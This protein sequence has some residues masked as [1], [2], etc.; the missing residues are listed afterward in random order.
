ML[1]CGW[2]NFFTFL[3]WISLVVFFRHLTSVISLVILSEIIWVLLY[4]FS[5]YIGLL[6]DDIN[7][8][9]IPFVIL[10]LASVEF[11]IIFLLLMLFRVFNINTT[12]LSYSY[13]SVKW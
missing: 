5:I 6:N 3:F 12:D 13:N 10:V 9:L 4:I 1:M 11:S 7:L 2:V 8:L